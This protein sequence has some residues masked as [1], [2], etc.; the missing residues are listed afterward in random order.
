MKQQ[1]GSALLISLVLLT[2]IT[3]IS[4]TGLQRSGLQT[5]I[6]ANN[7]HNE[8]AFH[9]AN[10][11]LEAVFQTYQDDSDAE[12]LN[13]AIDS[14]TTVD[15]ETVYDVIDSGITSHYEENAALYSSHI[16]VSSDLQHTGSSNFVSGY[17]IGEFVNY[18][19]VITA[20]ATTP[21][22]EQIL[23]SQELGLEFIGPA[24]Y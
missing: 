12:Q 2:A 20:D 23:S 15:S 22:G 18:T 6:V 21:S 9:A 16:Q 11:E 10:G 4:I 1:S 8:M 14:Y 19:F 13:T 17:S 3:L 7:Q 5:R 24:T